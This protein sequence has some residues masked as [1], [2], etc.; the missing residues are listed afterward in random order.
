MQWLHAVLVLAAIVVALVARNLGLTSYEFNV[1]AY[2][3]ER[4]GR[5]LSRTQIARAALSADGEV[6]DRTVDSHIA[7]VR[8]KLG[9]PAA[10]AFQTVWGIGYRF[11][12]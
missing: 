2:L 5:A 6:D 1:V 7:R 3:V 8:K 10:D 12:P 4:P 9:R 11:V